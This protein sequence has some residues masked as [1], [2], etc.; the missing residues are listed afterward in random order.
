MLRDFI[1]IGAL[2]ENE[3]QV[4]LRIGIRHG[5]GE[6]RIAVG[7]EDVDEAGVFSILRGHQAGQKRPRFRHSH[8]GT[9]RRRCDCEEAGFLVQFETLRHTLRERITA[10]EI[11]HRID[12]V[13]A[14]DRLLADAF[15]VLQHTILLLLEE[16][17]RARL[18]PDLLA[19]H[20]DRRPDPTQNENQQHHPK[21]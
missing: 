21:P 2:F 15:D 14:A 3:S 13:E 1:R 10:Q 5:G 20:K 6:S 11:D 7:D 4:F 9:S 17:N 18:K 12:H 16:K 19:I 8:F